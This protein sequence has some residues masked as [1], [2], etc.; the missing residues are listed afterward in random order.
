MAQ[1]DYN[2]ANQSGADFRADLNNAL[3]AIAST[4]SGDTEP[5]TT[6]ANQ[7]W[8]DTAN[9]VLKIRNEGNTDWVATGLSITADNTFIGTITAN[10][11]NI[12][13]NY[14]T[15]DSSSTANGAGITI[16]D[17]VSEGNDASFTWNTSADI[18]NLS[19]GL[20]IPDNALISIGDGDDLRLSHNGTASKIL[21]YTGH[22]DI[23]NLADGQDLRFGS[24]D[25]TGGV[26]NYF[27]LDGGEQISVASKNIRFEDNVKS[28]FGDSDDLEIYH[29]G[30]DSI[31]DDVGTGNLIIKSGGEIQT[32]TG[33]D[34]TGTVTS[35]GFT[36]T[37]GTVLVGTSSSTIDNSN[38]GA[39]I[40]QV[41][42]IK[43]SVDVAGGGIVSQAF[44]TAG[45][46]RV[47]GD[48]DLENTNNSYGAISD[49]S[50]KENIEDASPK[51]EKLKQVQIKTFNL[52]DHD[53]KQIGVIAQDL[54]N[55]FPSL[56][57]DNDDGY[58]TVKYSVFVPILIKAMQE[59]EQQVADLSEQVQ[60]L[61]N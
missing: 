38:H 55:V 41:G 11:A 32:T 61:Q 57:K 17:A 49:E 42:R 36:T 23:Q 2:I 16:Q 10:N 37:N 45:E 30:S 18:F 33:I 26:E 12:I 35:D 3:S 54:E 46:F 7:L 4:N 6:F 20:D 60:N 19:H 58:K 9:N 14:S 21:N 1:H 25:G 34:V 13:L 47:K 50:L 15:G 40:S 59:L 43:N 31:I 22:L 29:D 39:L 56:V 48:G 24:D 44:G 52:I 51:L 28:T 5:T 53:L 8:I 27:R